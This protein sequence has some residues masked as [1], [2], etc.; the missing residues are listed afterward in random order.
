[1]LKFEWDPTKAESN[2][3]KHGVTFEQ[4][5]TVFGDPLALTFPDPDG[6]KGEAR[7]LTFGL[8][9]SGKLTVVSHTERRGTIR[10][11]SARAATRHERKIYEQG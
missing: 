3:K 8:A 4:A 5:A 2:V 6:S 7:H 9:Q 1:M 10:I 11:I